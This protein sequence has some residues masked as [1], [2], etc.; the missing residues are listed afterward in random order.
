MKLFSTQFRECKKAGLTHLLGDVV[1]STDIETGKPITTQA[2]RCGRFG[3]ECSSAHPD[4]RKLRGAEP[5][6]EKP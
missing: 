4:C 6:R 3:G 2:Y 1:L 5:T